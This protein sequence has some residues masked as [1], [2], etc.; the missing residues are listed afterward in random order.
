MPP[1]VT[2]CAQKVAACAALLVL[3]LMA[4]YL[5]HQGQALLWS[6]ITDA[7]TTGGT[8]AGLITTP[9]TWEGAH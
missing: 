2:L 7:L 6:P 8:D 5:L 9:A 4:L 1:Y 3:A